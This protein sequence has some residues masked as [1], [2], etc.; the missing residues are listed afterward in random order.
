M[1][2]AS[3]PLITVTSAGRT[4]PTSSG[5]FSYLSLVSEP[6]IQT[7]PENLLVASGLLLVSKHWLARL[8]HTCVQ[9]GTTDK[10]THIPDCTLAHIQYSTIPMSWERV[11]KGT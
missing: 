9:E 7:R 3:E 11:A 6:P 1:G 5:P 4:Q 8:L 10:A 2:G